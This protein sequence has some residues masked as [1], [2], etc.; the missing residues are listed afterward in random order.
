[1]PISRAALRHFFARAATNLHL[2]PGTGRFNVGSAKP[3][4]VLI[5]RALILCVDDNQTTLG[6]LNEV[7]ASKGFVVLLA[8]TA[9]QA[10]EILRETPVSLVIADHMLRGTT[11]VELAAQ[12]KATKPTVPVVLHSGINPDTVRHVD[13]FIHK[14]EPVEAFLSLVSDLVKRFSS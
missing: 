9:E 12:F 7:L 10:V 11:G 13:A 6:L 8:S 2:W 3:A 1:M 5:G 14:G 4:S